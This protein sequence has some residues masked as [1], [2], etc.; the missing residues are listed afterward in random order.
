MTPQSVLIGLEV[1][2]NCMDSS[3]IFRASNVSA[4][5]LVGTHDNVLL[6]TFYFV[7]N[8][9]MVSDE[10]YK[11][12]VLTVDKLN[13]FKSQI[14]MSIQLIIDREG[15]R[16][17]EKIALSQ[18]LV[19]HELRKSNMPHE[20][21]TVSEIATKYGISKSEVRRRKADGTLEEFLNN[22]SNK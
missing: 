22:L 6:Q 5:V 1:I 8:K 17:Q 20:L 12:D 2:A 19:R 14:R 4:S 18:Q 10:E 13:N 11:T 7:A 16:H 15:L 9:K 3:N 21:G